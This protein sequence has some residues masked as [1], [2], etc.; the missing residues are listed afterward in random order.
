[1]NMNSVAW[2][3]K[4]AAVAEQK[5]VDLVVKSVRNYH[6]NN[7]NKKQTETV[8]SYIRSHIFIVTMKNFTL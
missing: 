2:M 3:M 7:N 4:L 5:C 1:M 6:V 8:I